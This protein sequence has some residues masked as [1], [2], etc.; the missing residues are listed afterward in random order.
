MIQFKVTFGY[1]DRKISKTVKIQKGDDKTESSVKSHVTMEIRSRE[2]QNK[3]LPCTLDASCS[4]TVN[5][6]KLYQQELDQIQE[7]ISRAEDNSQTQYYSGLKCCRGDEK[8][9]WA[10]L[11]ISKSQA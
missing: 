11:L 6:F 8:K 3:H 4:G 7:D 1:F 2:K 10:F 5:K 9:I